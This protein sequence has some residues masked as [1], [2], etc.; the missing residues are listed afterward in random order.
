MRYALV[1]AD[2]I[3]VNLIV[4]DD[5]EGYT[6]QDG[7]LVVADTD[8]V[9]EVGGSWTGDHFEPAPPPPHEEPVF[10]AKLQIETLKD[11]V[12]ALEERLA[13]IESPAQQQ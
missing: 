1:D 9:A 7:F 5:P 13:A 4:L 2:G 6:P 10:N 8:D 3:V 12:S 11:R